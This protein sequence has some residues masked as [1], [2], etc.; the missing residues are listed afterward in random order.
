MILFNIINANFFKD[1]FIKQF[2]KC[3]R[4]F[5]FYVLFFFFYWDAFLTIFVLIVLL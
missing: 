1:Y 3:S 5:F 2:A 4:F